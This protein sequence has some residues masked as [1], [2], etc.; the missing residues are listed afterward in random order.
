LAPLQEAVA[1]AAAAARGVRKAL[2]E[3]IEAALKGRRWGPG[4]SMVF[5]LEV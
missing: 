1:A 3:D 5:T 2:K 4:S